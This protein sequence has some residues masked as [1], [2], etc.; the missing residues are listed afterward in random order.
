M[1]KEDASP[2]TTADFAAQVCAQML[3]DIMQI[4]VNKLL[5]SSFPSDTMISEEVI[6]LVGGF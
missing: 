2:V 6:E 5:K 4:L 1:T 3:S